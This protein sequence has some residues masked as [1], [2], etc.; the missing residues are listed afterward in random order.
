MCPTG[1][2]M[3]MFNAVFI[4]IRTITPV[5]CEVSKLTALSATSCS[6]VWRR[7][8]PE[9]CVGPDMWTS[10]PN[11]LMPIGSSPKPPSANGKPEGNSK[12]AGAEDNFCSNRYRDFDRVR[13]DVRERHE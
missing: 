11:L 8:C 13:T 10:V 12:P 4:C 1:A 9:F 2:Y 6:V 7:N 5:T 3:C